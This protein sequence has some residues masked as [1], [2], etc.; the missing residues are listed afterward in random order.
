MKN[1]YFTIDKKKDKQVINI[2]KM[3]VL[4]KYQTINEHTVNALINNEVWGTVPTNFNDPYDM[5]FCYSIS[6]IRKAIRKKL[7]EERLTKY[8]SFFQTKNTS[9]LVKKISDDLLSNYN[10]NF[11][12]QYC[13]SCFSLVNNSE[14]MWGH[15]ANC[16]KGFVVAYNGEDL[17]NVA[18]ENNNKVFDF[19]KT[20]NLYDIDFS[21]IK[22]DNLTTVAPVIY[23]NGKMNLDREIINVLDPIL[24][25]Y[26]D[27]LEGKTIGEAFGILYSKFNQIRL[28]K[29]SLYNDTFY[30]AL[31]NK[32]RDWAYEQEWR[33]WSYNSNT[34]MGQIN[35]PHICIGNVKPKAIYLGEKI[36]PYDEQAMLAIAKEKLNIPVYKMKTKMFKNRCKLQAELLYKGVE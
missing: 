13:V 17:Q 20:S 29:Q 6:N 28:T 19:I 8:H 9:M 24:E 15:Y 12:K 22:Q 34:L 36:S 5:I 16:A 11:R 35:D 7:T 27:V 10:D 25:C 30:S 18:L 26:D 33:I 3:P 2:I 14:I 31:C 1:K 21:K 32:N 23:S 4:Y